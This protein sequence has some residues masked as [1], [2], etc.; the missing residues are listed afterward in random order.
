MSLAIMRFGPGIKPIT[1]PTPSRWA[2]C[3]ATDAGSKQ[4]VVE[5]MPELVECELSFIPGDENE[6]VEEDDYIR[7]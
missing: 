2:K 4:F 3:Y 1:F 7:V 6:V 5:P